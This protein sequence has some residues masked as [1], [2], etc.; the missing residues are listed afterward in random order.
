MIGAGPGEVYK[1]P[2]ESRGAWYGSTMRALVGLV[3][4]AGCFTSAAP[5]AAPRPEPKPARRT[6]AL[7]DALG[8]L[9]AESTVIAVIEVKDLRASP[10]WARLEPTLQQ[11]VDPLLPGGFSKNCQ[12]DPIASLKRVAIGLREVDTPTPSGV[13]VLRGY[14]RELVMA[15]LELAK[16]TAGPSK[17][18]IA[19]GVALLQSGPLRAAVT[20]ADDTTLVI[21]IGANADAISLAGVIDGGAPLRSTP[22]F[23]EAIGNLDITAPMW[24][25]ILDPKLLAGAAMGLKPLQATASGRLVDGASSQI[26]IRL[27]DPALAS[28]TATSLQSQMS[29]AA[30]FFEELTVTD[31]DAD[32]VVRMRMNPSQLEMVLGMLLGNAP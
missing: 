6:V 12:F 20:F 23:L 4:V 24:V 8:F 9:P 7:T 11:R 21:Q 13:V 28:T 16:T 22:S 3:L 14:R 26:R 25:A 29:A 10:A 19:D 15:C 2:V 32:L 17:I 27:D 30:M 1:P 5:P 18:T 31:E